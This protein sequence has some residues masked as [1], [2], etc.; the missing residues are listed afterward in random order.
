MR[1]LK[2]TEPAQEDLESIWEYIVARGSR[3][4]AYKVLKTITSTFLL[5]RDHPNLGTRKDH[6]LLG[7]RSFSVKKYIIYYQPFDDR[8]RF[9]AWCIAPAI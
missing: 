8:M 5:L 6:L 9:S 3:E 1:E 2:V 7:L 4:S